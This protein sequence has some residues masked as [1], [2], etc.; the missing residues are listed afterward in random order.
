MIETPT[1]VVFSPEAIVRRQSASWRGLTAEIVQLSRLEPF[2]Y[3][4]QGPCHLLI[5]S[6][7]AARRDG[8][9]FVEGLPRST[10]REF[11]QKLTFVPAGGEFFGWQEPKALTRV[12]Y[13][14]IDSNGPLIDPATVRAPQT[15]TMLNN[16][17]KESGMDESRSKADGSMKLG[18][19]A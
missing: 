17:I 6:H 7:R 5:A 18:K 19:V 13:F 14:Y 11:S 15:T 4:L 10:R 16:I 12:S 2:E 8:E 9:T 3:R 1:G